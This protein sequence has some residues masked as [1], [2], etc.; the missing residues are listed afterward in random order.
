MCRN[1]SDIVLAIPDTKESDPLE[2]QAKS[3]NCHFYRG[4]EHDVLS[5]YYHAARAF[6]IDTV[7]RITGDCPLIDPMV[8]DRLVGD[9]LGSGMYDYMSVDSEGNFPRGLDTEIFGFETLEQ[10]HRDAR[11][12]YEREH[13]TPYIYQH[14]DLFRV[15]FVEA[16]GK[17]RRPGLRLTVDTEDDLLLV[18][19][20]YSALY[21]DHGNQFATEDVLALIDGNPHLQ[22]I[23]KHI[24]QKDMHSV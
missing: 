9:F 16:Q 15:L 4:D 8:I 3:M 10:I 23:N 21:A 24:V 11:L 12:A 14:R 2:V 17:L 1:I 20:I 22:S 7:I 6:R 19:E 18:R 13:V 5:R